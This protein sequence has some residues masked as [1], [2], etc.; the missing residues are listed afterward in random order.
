LSRWRA[1]SA[2]A[3]SRNA[4]EN[5]SNSTRCRATSGKVEAR[6]RVAPALGELFESL[7]RAGVVDQAAERAAESVAAA[8]VDRHITSGPARSAES[9]R[10]SPSGVVQRVD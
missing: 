7:A 10:S 5:T 6:D 4:R 3:Y 2:L 1:D 9:R 8:L